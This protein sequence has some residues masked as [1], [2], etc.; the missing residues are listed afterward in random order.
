MTDEEIVKKA[1]M[2]IPVFYE[3]Y[4]I[5]I[6]VST[7]IIS[8]LPIDDLPAEGSYGSVVT[9][10]KTRLTPVGHRWDLYDVSKR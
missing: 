10:R 1:R 4:E 5:H 9:F 3:A 6:P 2:K 7:E 8:V